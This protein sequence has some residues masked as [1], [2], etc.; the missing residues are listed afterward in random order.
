MKQSRLV[1]RA[2][3]SKDDKVKITLSLVAAE[4]TATFSPAAFAS[5]ISLKTPGLVSTCPLPM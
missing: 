1:K 4:H 2:S 5:S 3:P